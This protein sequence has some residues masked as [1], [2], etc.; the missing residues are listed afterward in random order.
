METEDTG[1]EDI[2]PSRE[3]NFLKYMENVVDAETILYTG[4]V[5]AVRGLEIESEGPRSVIGEM[6]S[7]HLR[8]GTSLPAEV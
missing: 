2:L 6:C 7:I 1:A 8:N 5:T 4:K 3:F